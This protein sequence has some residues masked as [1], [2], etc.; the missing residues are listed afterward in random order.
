MT[1]ESSISELVERHYILGGLKPVRVQVRSFPGE[2]I[3]LVEVDKDYE[4]A[5]VLAEELDK[6]ID[7]GFVTV[8]RVTP[9]SLKR[10]KILVIAGDCKAKNGLCQYI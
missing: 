7:N 4:R 3:A 5:L 8:R 10:V 9:K 1:T 6:Q 2:T